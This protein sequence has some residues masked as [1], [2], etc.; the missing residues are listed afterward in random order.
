MSQPQSILL[1]NKQGM[2]VEIINFGAR[3]KSIL[4]P[5]QGKPTEMVVGYATAEEYLTDSFYLGA[6]C[7][8]V[9][10]RIDGGKFELNGV[11]YQ[12]TQN[13][14]NNT[15]HGGVDNFSYRFWKIES[16][17]DTK[18]V[19]S[20]ESKDGDQGF[21]GNLKLQVSY[22]LTE[23][24]ALEI[25]YFGISDAATPINITNHAYFNLGDESCESLDLQLLA[26]NFLEL[27]ED[28][29][30][31]GNI[32]S[33]DNSDFDLRQVTNIGDR[34]SNTTD[35]N[36]KNMKGFDYCYVLD[37]NDVSIVNASLASKNNG[38][39][40]SFYTDQLAVQLYTGY[41]LSGVFKPYQGVCLEAQG[42][43]NA[44]NINHFPSS[45]LS[46]NEKYQR[47]IIY[48]FEAIN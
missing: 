18:V 23:K 47:K 34:Q 32:L 10:N 19:L 17:T 20:L 1:Q 2:S 43:T 13:E 16:S 38:V 48:Q 46:E 8:R 9:C 24:N 44:I 25:E 37:N 42:Y 31:S 3:I 14:N 22:H 27:K 11:S 15:L 33:V 30:P 21:P 45:V 7:G 26:S 40:M 41:W 29:V 36:L 6:T 5:I 35:V 39:K 28:S 12:V 4:F